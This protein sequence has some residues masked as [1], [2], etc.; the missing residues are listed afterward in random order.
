[1]CIPTADLREENLRAGTV[2]KSV[3]R[4]TALSRAR[5]TGLARERMGRVEKSSR[6]RVKRTGNWAEEMRREPEFVEL[7]GRRKV[8]SCMVR[9]RGQARTLEE[10]CPP[11]VQ[12]QPLTHFAA[13]NAHQTLGTAVRFARPGVENIIPAY[14]ADCSLALDHAAVTFG[15]IRDC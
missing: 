9:L 12:V 13:K 7:D 10:R 6:L 14:R 5:K 11:R 4:M 2:G 3:G 15:I 8:R 1:M